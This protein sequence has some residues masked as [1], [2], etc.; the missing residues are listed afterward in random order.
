MSSISLNSTFNNDN[1]LKII[2]NIHN[3]YDYSY[4]NI[5]NVNC[6]TKYSDLLNNDNSII[7]MT[8]YKCKE[9]CISLSSVFNKSELLDLSKFIYEKIITFNNVDYE[10][11]KIIDLFT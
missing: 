9:N 8:T 3:F 2:H 11:Q 1:V 10:F 4:D 7:D 6:I 5:I